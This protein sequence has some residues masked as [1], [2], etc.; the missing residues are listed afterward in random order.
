MHNS[1]YSIL[2]SE[3]CLTDVQ[4]ESVFFIC[5]VILLIIDINYYFIPLFYSI[6]AYKCKFCSRAFPRNTDLRIHERYHTNDKRHVMFIYFIID[7]D[8]FNWISFTNIFVCSFA[9]QV[10]DVCGKGFQRSYNL[11]VHKRVHTGEKPYG[12]IQQLFIYF[13]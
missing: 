4:A 9:F 10:C 7:I 6:L 5:N 8:T 1:I 12:V 2:S 13:I 11:L 3:W